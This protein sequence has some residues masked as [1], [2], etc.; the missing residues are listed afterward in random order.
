MVYVL[1]L[2]GSLGSKSDVVQEWINGEIE[3]EKDSAA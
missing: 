3:R 2:L 1:I